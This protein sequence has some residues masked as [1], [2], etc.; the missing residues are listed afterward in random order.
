L[1]NLPCVY[2]CCNKDE[3]DLRFSFSHLEKNTT[4]GQQSASAMF[5]YTVT[6]Q[7]SGQKKGNI[8]MGEVLN[9]ENRLSAALF[10]L[11]I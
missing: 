5:F 8:I 2:Y 11:A 9:P 4:E 3:K 6:C 10:I 7:V 1:G